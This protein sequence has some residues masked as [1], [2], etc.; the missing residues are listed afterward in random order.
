MF[1]TNI[2][3]KNL[4]VCS[5]FNKRQ[6]FRTCH[7]TAENFHGETSVHQQLDI[8]SQ[9]MG[10]AIVNKQ[11]APIKVTSDKRSEHDSNLLCTKVPF[12][13]L[14]SGADMD[15]LVQGCTWNGDDEC[16]KHFLSSYNFTRGTPIKKSVPFVTFDRRVDLSFKKDGNYY[17]LDDQGFINIMD[18]SSVHNKTKLPAL[19]PL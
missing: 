3:P 4:N 14:A 5:N 8:S 16:P 10:L 6:E 1:R 19:Q 13:H 17:M 9:N 7:I 12:E 15:F 2:S 11:Q 18:F